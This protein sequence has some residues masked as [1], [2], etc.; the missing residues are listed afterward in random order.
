MN[1]KEVLQAFREETPVRFG[2]FV[3]TRIERVIYKHVKYNQYIES[4]TIDDVKTR[5]RVPATLKIIQAACMD[6]RGNEYI[7]N[8]TRLIPATAEEVNIPC[9]VNHTLTERLK[10]LK[11]FEAYC[12]TEDQTPD[13]ETLITFLFAEDLINA[14]KA[15]NVVKAYEKSE[16]S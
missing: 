8:P 15:Y 13:I 3:F 9:E 12:D 11:V 2:D 7:L 10:L 16:R 5:L 4:S 6:R 14:S 1:S